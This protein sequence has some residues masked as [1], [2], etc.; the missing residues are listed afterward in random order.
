MGIDRSAPML[1]LARRRVA[2][3]R[4]S[5]RPILIR[6]DIRAIP[7]RTASVELVIAPYGIL[8]SL[9]RKP[10][11]SRT[12]AETARVLRPGGRFIAD[13]VPD[14]PTWEPYQRQVRLHGRHGKGQVTLVESVRQDRQ[15]GLTTFD[16]EFIEHAPPRPGGAP[17]APVTARFSLTFRT[18]S[19]AEIRRRLER[20]GFRVE[21]ILGGY[22]GQRW[23]SA[24]ETWL[25]VAR[26]R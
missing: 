17:A 21:R 9:I 10:D 23:T 5:R 26:K 13:L 8:Q 22:R 2:R 19:M 12:L 1:R 3:L 14:L 6:G 7:L 18:L 25:I 16:E 15:R 20:T 24:S 11:L 4:P